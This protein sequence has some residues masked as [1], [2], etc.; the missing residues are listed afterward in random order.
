VTGRRA[1]GPRGWTPAA[2]RIDEVRAAHG[3][4]LYRGTPGSWECECGAI[5]VDRPGGTHSAHV[6]AMVEGVLATL[7]GPRW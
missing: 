6:D 3:Q 2:R 1:A 5:G 7:R 4:V